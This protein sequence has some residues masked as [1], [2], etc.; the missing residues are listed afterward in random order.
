MTQTEVR[1]FALYLANV[2]LEEFAEEIYGP[3]FEVDSYISEKYSRM[4][5]NT[6]AWLCELDEIRLSNLAMAVNRRK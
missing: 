6:I 2:S 1:Q 4:N 3:T 5:S